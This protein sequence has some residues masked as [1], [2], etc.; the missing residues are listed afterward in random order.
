MAWL[1]ASSPCP[2][3]AVVGMTGTPSPCASFS[4]LILSPFVSA[5]SAMFSAT[6]T[7]APISIICTTRYKFRSR[8]AASA[9]TTT[10]SGRASMIKSRAIISSIENAVRLYVPGKSTTVYVWPL[11]VQLPSFFSTVFPGQFPTCC[12]APVSALNTVL[13]PT[14]GLPAK[15]IVAV[16]IVSLLKIV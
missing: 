14:L 5:M 8:L 11:Y 16:V 3:R 15:A 2:S 13:F 9:T 6:I 1:K 4:T 10:A 12:R 7:G